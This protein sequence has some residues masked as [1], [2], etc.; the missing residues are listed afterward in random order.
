MDISVPCHT[1]TSLHNTLFESIYFEH[2][3]ATRRVVHVCGVQSAAQL[4]RFLSDGRSWRPPG[5]SSAA[6]SPDRVFPRRAFKDG[7]AHS[8]C[9][10]H[11]FAC[12][13]S[14]RLC[15]E[16]CGPWGF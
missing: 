7:G 3:H 9:I 8:C 4:S 12:E 2:V 6:T 10:D 1:T 13:R 16:Y 14:H 11:G 15:V 5:S